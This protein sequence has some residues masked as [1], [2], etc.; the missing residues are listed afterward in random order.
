MNIHNDTEN[1]MLSEFA[2]NRYYGDAPVTR[3]AAQAAY[4]ATEK[5]LYALPILRERIEDNREELTELENMG[6][7]ALRH[8]SSSLVRLIRP[9]MR[10]TPEEVH[11]A[12]MAELRARLA[13]DEREVRKLQNALHSVAEDPYYLTIELK[14]FSGVKDADAAAR[15]RCD[16]A[17]VRRN[18]NRLVK[19]LAL[20]LY[21][22][23]CI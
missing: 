6:V 21:G 22:V 2:L 8:H 17:T 18:R 15:L 1:H 20:R 11:S 4:A 9:G 16:P 5:R 7:E 13:A 14:Y 19:R 23:D 10:L 3:N 12:Q